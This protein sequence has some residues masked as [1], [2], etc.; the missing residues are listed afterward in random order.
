[1]QDTYDPFSFLLSEIR[2]HDAGLREDWHPDQRS[3]YLNHLLADEAE[4]I[5]WGRRH[6]SAVHG[7]VR[8]EAHAELID[9]LFSAWEDL[10]ARVDW[11]RIG[12]VADQHLTFTVQGP[13]AN[14]L[15]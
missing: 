4:E 15:A 12:G 14:A 3:Q 7:P 8:D 6:I 5:A 10:S 2:A 11:S 9:E 1:M 13:T